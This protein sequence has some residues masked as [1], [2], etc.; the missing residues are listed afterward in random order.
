LNIHIMW[1]PKRGRVQCWKKFANKGKI[2]KFGKWHKPI[3][4]SILVNLKHKS[5]EIHAPK[6]NWADERWGKSYWKQPEEKKWCI[7]YR[8][9]MMWMFVNFLSEAYEATKKWAIWNVLKENNPQSRILYTAK[10]YFRNEG[11]IKIFS[12]EG[13]LRQEPPALKEV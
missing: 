5:K 6:H 9:I 12:D 7:T 4:S 10:N 1:V 3:D 13:K 8:E 11:K 2:L